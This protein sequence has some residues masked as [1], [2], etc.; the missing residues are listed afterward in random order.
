VLADPVEGLS[1]AEH[2]KALRLMGLKAAHYLAAAVMDAPADKVEHYELTPPDQKLPRI[3]YVSLILAQ[4]LL[5]D[6]YVYGLN[7][8]KTHTMLM[9]PN[10]YFDGAVVSGNCVSACSKTTTFDH[11]NNPVMLD[12]YR[13]HGV[14]LDFAGVITSPITP[15]LADKERGVMGVVNVAK[16]LGVDG[17]IIAYEGGGNPESDLMML[18]Q[19]AEKAGIKTVLMSHENA[20][21]DGIAQGLAMVVPEADAVVTMGNVNEAIHLPK[22]DRVIGDLAA[23][24][25]LAG[26]PTDALRPDGSM[27]S[28]VTMITES[29]G[30]IG[31]TK[32]S[33][34]T[35]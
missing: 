6:N 18:C 30:N 14:D 9:S 20:G 1:H 31:Y 27:K 8:Q 2:E 4:G 13:H 5:H 28:I 12:L 7:A 33:A 19:R 11:E 29:A 25:L 26:V 3:A 34:T 16:M 32:L 17:L 15:V 23:V 21:W 22:M 10:E 35:Y 24:K